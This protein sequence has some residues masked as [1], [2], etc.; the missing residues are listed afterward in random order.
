MDLYQNLAEKVPLIEGK[1]GYVFKNK[2]VLMLAFVHRSF[3]NEHRYKVA[4]HNERLE[5]LGDSVLNILTSEYLYK[6]YPSLSEG[7]LS[8][9]RAYLVEAAMCA[10]LVQKLDLSEFILLGRGEKMSEG[11]NKESIQSDL[12]EALLGSI[13]IDGG[14]EEARKFFWGHFLD[15]VQKRIKEPARNWKAELQDYF[16][17][18]HQKAPIY[19]LLSAQG[20][21]HHKQFEVAVYM[22][23]LL[24]GTGVGSSKKEAEQEAAKK[25][26][27]SLER[28]SGKERS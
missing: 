8:H 19:H 20:P 2:D 3:Y 27:E 26:M 10:R 5:F 24:L 11:K 21:D 15:D 12:F 13:Y 23:D 22:E 18:R 7:Q 28:P 9:T 25:A 6:E 17:K 16:Q 14:F 4:E 1:I